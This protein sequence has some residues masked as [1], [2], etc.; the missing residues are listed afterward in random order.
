MIL[1]ISFIHLSIGVVL[2]F[3]FLYSS[4]WI[5]LSPASLDASS[6]FLDQL[7][8]SWGLNPAKHPFPYRP[9]ADDGYWDFPVLPHGRCGDNG[10]ALSLFGEIFVV[11]LPRRTDRK[12][13]MEKLKMELGLNWTYVDATSADDGS[14]LV[15]M[16]EVRRV[17]TNAIKPPSDSAGSF[18]WP[19]ELDDLLA[20]AV[21]G[22]LGSDL[23]TL[24]SLT[25]PHE[26]SEDASGE[27]AA[28]RVPG[29]RRIRG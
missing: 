25:S 26:I 29:L 24:K 14:V 19:A 6:Y 13:D 11:S 2:V 7:S 21:T 15:I 10:G 27:S 12:A 28:E 20:T 1:S 17:R 8:D 9:G 5:L 18:Q 4:Y 16:D 3:G 22:L 23:W